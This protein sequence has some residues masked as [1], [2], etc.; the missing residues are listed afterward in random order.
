[1]FDWLK[2]I[3]RKRYISEN[4]MDRQKCFVSFQE[5]KQVGILTTITNED[6]YKEIFSIF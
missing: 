4:R 6:D 2:R 1:M 5:A 3:N